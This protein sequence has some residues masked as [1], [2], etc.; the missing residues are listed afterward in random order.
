[1]PATCPSQAELERLVAGLLD[2][3][4]QAALDEHVQSCPNCL[5]ALD[6]LATWSEVKKPLVQESDCPPPAGPSAGDSGFPETVLYDGDS[7]ELEPTADLP[8]S[9]GPTDRFPEIPGYQLQSRVAEGG[10]GTVYL[11]Q[12]LSLGRLVA[13]KVLPLPE[14]AGPQI[15][16]RF[17]RHAQ[18]AT[19]LIHPHIVQSLEFGLTSACAFLA[20]E[21]V[22][23]TSLM[24]VLRQQ[25]YEPRQAAALVRTLALTLEVAHRQGIVHGDLKPSH[26][27]LCD[28]ENPK[29]LDFG[30]ATI[31]AAVPD[32]GSGANSVP[33]HRSAGDMAPEQVYSAGNRPGISPQTDIYG[34][35]AILYAMLTGRPLFAGD[36]SQETLRLVIQEAPLP[37]RRLRPGVPVPLEIIANTCLSKSPAD[38]YPSAKALAD[39]LERFLSGQSIG[40]RPAGGFGGMKRAWRHWPRMVSSLLWGGAVLAVCCVAMF[41]FQ[42]LRQSNQELTASRDEWRSAVRDVSRERD[43]ARALNAE[44]CLARG[45]SL[46]ESGQANSGVWWLIEAL[47]LVP[48]SEP[49]L[50]QAIGSS[51]AAWTVVGPRLVNSFSQPNEFQSV[52]LSHD[53]RFAV[54]AGSEGESARIHDIRT[55]KRIASQT[56]LGIRPVAV[57]PDGQSFVVMDAAGTIRRFRFEDGQQLDEAFESQG[58][59]ADTLSYSPDGSVLFARSH[60]GRGKL[61]LWDVKSGRIQHSKSDLA[62]I[63]A[64]NDT[65]AW[66]ASW[67]SADSSQLWLATSTGVRGF[68]FDSNQLEAVPGWPQPILAVSPN[69]QLAAVLAGRNRIQ[70]VRLTDGVSEFGPV[71]LEAMPLSVEFHPDG[72]LVA[73]GHIDGSL[74]LVSVKTGST[75][76]KIWTTTGEIRAVVF[77]EDG[78]R[79]MFGGRNWAH[80]LDLTELMPGAPVVLPH[81]SDVSTFEL[82]DDGR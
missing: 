11:A 15:R 38:R 71:E 74:R 28:S 23:G 72:S 49:E 55:G 8:P 1:M 63:A 5:A 77:S 42:G 67:W 32:T 82:S 47:R 20:S 65:S 78:S 57:H 22:N 37:I 21:Y 56:F 68:R 62:E 18:L 30:L 6:D 12:Q 26:I 50:K 10:L 2:T 54:T 35:G 4:A 53:G 40:P 80:L 61:W 24:D 19:G 33:F 25:P 29:I 39:D 45:Q 60:A 75:L 16:E 3:A 79:L 81:E 31:L 34:L 70:F 9:A 17:S 64:G 66:H 43:Q 59:P 44:L 73:I 36:T 48:E 27:L 58:E 69:R 14:S 52:A 41:L 13:L 76:G 51:L 7:E 46:G